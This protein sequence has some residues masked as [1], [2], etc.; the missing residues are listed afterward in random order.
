VS[1]LFR[2]EVLE[3]RKHRLFG[4]VTLTQPV[5]SWILAGL[6]VVMTIIALI[7]AAFGTYARIE[8][9][10]GF[11]AATSPVAKIQALRPGIVTKLHVK[12]GALVQAGAALVSVRLESANAQTATPGADAATSI[13]QQISIAENQMQVEQQRMALQRTKQA[14][15]I[16]AAQRA[17]TSLARQIELQRTIVAS[18]KQAFEQLSELV[19]K[20]Y[21]SKIEYER[22]RQAYLALEQQLQQ[23]MQQRTQAIAQIAQLIT[24]AAQS[25]L[26]MRNR[27]G[28]LTSAIQSLRQRLGAG[29][30]E[31]AYVITAPIAGR[32]TALQTGLGRVANPN[33]PLMTIVPEGAVLE[34][35][36][37]APSRA[38]GFMAA[39]QDV[40]V[41]YDAFPYQRFGSFKGNIQDVSHT[42]LNP[43]EID[44]P[45]KLD[46][47]AYPLTV[48]LD[49]QQ[50]TA[51]GQPIRLQPGMTLSANIVLDRRSFL[52][53]LLEPLRAV[54]ARS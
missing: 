53:W 10:P 8:T 24:E 15:A 43:G 6:L 23:L 1:S 28:D 25:P 22:R 11:L 16:D 3:A 18:A 21:T 38:A 4:D 12:D 32:I 41:R 29:S 54:G 44:G 45:V 31:Q 33:F 9:V 42:V 37:Y 40:R 2:E 7:M 30:S 39:G 19:E 17:S 13:R 51:F 48:R 5:S 47:P 36:L 49:Q 46:E 14:D 20:G 35:H 26:E 34:A 27:L 52:D 50:I